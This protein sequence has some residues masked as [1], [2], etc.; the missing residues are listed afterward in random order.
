MD[1]SELTVI[2]PVGGEAKR[3]QPLTTEVSKA[4]IR[5]VGRPVVEFALIELAK[6]GVRNFIFGVKGYV[7]YKSLFDYFGEGTGFSAKYKIEPRAHIRYQ[8][9]IEDVGSADS[10]RINMEYYDINGETMVVQ[11]DNIFEL[12][13]RSML[14]L[15][16]ENKA[17]MTIA[18]TK[19][20]DVEA[21]GIADLRSDGRIRRFV[22]KPKK[23][24]AP[25][26]YANTGIYILSPAVRSLFRSSE[27]E[28]LITQRRRLDFGMDFIPYLVEKNYP[29][30]GYIS[31]GEWMDVGTPRG[32]LQAMRS[33]LNSPSAKDRF[34][35]PI[36]ELG[37][38][39]IRGQSK[40]AE[41]RR[42]EIISKARQGKIRIEGCV[43]IGRHTRIGDGTVIKDSAIDN[44][45]VIGSN[46][47]IE[48][49]SLMDGVV[50]GEGAQIQD[51]IIGRYVDIR[52]SLLKPTWLVG[53]CVIG[54]DAMIDEGSTLVSSRILPHA[55]VMKGSSKINEV[56]TG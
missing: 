36:A 43:L 15:H 42:E 12:D 46:V 37:R 21:Y 33:L 47:T 17:F 39:W 32:Y 26:K 16:E 7:N 10:V 24:E 14:Q 35:E 45:C 19:V 23:E 2:I 48:R 20:S 52:S 54:D 51:S 34:G 22:E 31:D 18:L 38:V 50:V 11:G 56:V 4:L 29:V 8:P 9:R 53:L 6:Q 13:L 55:R 27:L 44:Y 25:S 30:Y 40:E 1:P 3:M 5:I 28:S 49:S 41:R